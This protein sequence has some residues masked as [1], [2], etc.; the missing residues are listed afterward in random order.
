MRFAVDADS[1]VAALALRREGFEVSV[2]PGGLGEDD[3]AATLEAASDADCVVVDHYGADVD[4]LGAIA[5]SK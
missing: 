2:V 4:Y 3:L 1:A 5:D